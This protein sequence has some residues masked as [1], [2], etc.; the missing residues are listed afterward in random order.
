MVAIR[1]GI[2]EPIG[3]EAQ[4]AAEAVVALCM[5]SASTAR[6]PLS[7]PI[8]S[9]SRVIDT[10]TA[11]AM[12]STRCTARRLSSRCGAAADGAPP[13]LATPIARQAGNSA[14]KVLGLGSAHQLS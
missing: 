1:L 9:F 2:G 7:R 5:A 11:R 12:S 6:E 13:V 10:F 4:Q 8:T 14:P 3:D